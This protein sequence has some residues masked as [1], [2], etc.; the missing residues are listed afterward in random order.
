MNNNS[1]TITGSITSVGAYL[2]SINQINLYMQLILGLLSGAASIYTIVNIYKQN[3][4]ECKRFHA[5][6][7]CFL[8]YTLLNLQRQEIIDPA[9]TFLMDSNR[10]EFFLHRNIFLYFNYIFNN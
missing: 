6:A 5:L 7:I 4:P 8:F 3:N 10:K 9:R 1:N 2:L